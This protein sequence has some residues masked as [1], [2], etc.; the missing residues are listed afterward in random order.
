M[1]VFNAICEMIYNFH[2]GFPF[3]LSALMIHVFDAFCEMIYN[4]RA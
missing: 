3:Q 1:Y 4:F 2:A